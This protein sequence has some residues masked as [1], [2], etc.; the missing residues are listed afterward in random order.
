MKRIY[1]VVFLLAAALFLSQSACGGGN[2]T[3]SNANTSVQNSTANTNAPAKESAAS[4]ENTKTQPGNAN[5]N[6]STDENPFTELVMLYSEMFTA[7][8]KGNRA[9]VES[10]LAED[11]RETTGDGKTLNKSQV[12]ETISPDK[13]YDSYSLDKL[14]STTTGD[15]GVV[16][17]HVSVIIQGKED[18]WNFSETFAKRQGRW[19]AT[20]LKITDY[21][22][23][24]TPTPNPLNK[25]IQ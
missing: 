23:S 15:T 7:R 9:K 14:K 6:A 12:L 22:K 5:A 25:A 3:N 18:S 2:Q 11:Y 8:M 20:A 16:T 1:G 4:N 10:L 19:Q 21:K 24:Q 17:G 13:K